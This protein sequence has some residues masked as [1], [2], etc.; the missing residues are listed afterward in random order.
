ML[1]LDVESSVVL[2]DSLEVAESAGMLEE[3]EDE[4]APWPVEDAPWSASM[5]DELVPFDVWYACS[6]SRVS[7]PSRLPSMS[8]K[9]TASVGAAAWI[10]A[11]ESLPSSSTSASD[12]WLVDSSAVSLAL[13]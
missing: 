3:L 7:W 5:L 9:L 8:W 2:D 10:S 6:S 1:E 4:D 13:E 12:Q 11:C